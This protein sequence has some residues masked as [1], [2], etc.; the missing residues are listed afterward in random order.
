MTSCGRYTFAAHCLLNLPAQQAPQ[1][2]VLP[3]PKPH[4]GPPSTAAPPFPAAAWLPPQIT[5]GEWF[6]GRYRPPAALKKELPQASAAAAAAAAA[7]CCRSSVRR[8]AALPFLCHPLCRHAVLCSC[9]SPAPHLS[10]LQYDVLVMATFPEGPDRLPAQLALL[11][12]AG[13]QARQRQLLALHNPDHVIK[14]P[15]ISS[16]VVPY[17]VQHGGGSLA[18][19]KERDG[20]ADATVGGEADGGAAG[21]GGSGTAAAAG[22]RLLPTR[23]QPL[24]LAPFVASYTRSLL[25]TYAERRGGA[26]APAVHTPWLPPLVPAKA[27]DG[28]VP[29]AELRHLC[30]QA[31]GKGKNPGLGV[32]M[33]PRMSLGPVRGRCFCRHPP[34]DERN[35]AVHSI[36]PGQPFHPPPHTPPPPPLPAV[37]HAGY[38]GPDAPQ[39]RRCL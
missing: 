2:W 18:D 11:A 36:L 21:D 33:R 13:K 32:G 1:M 12:A 30:I 27:L 22:R 5:N 17:V 3:A 19:S 31:S 26:V 24:A 38:G 16:A 8:A 4:P 6:R 9:S 20:P 23:M 25:E 37:C 14:F 28:G 39:L 35:A 34:N 29:E 7:R 15:S 10:R